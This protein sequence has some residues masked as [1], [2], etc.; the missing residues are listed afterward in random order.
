MNT[1]KLGFLVLLL[2]MNLGLQASH[3]PEERKESIN[4]SE[5]LPDESAKNLKQ[6]STLDNNLTL[7]Q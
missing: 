1:L 2:S 3:Q 5:M 6:P 4:N 7:C